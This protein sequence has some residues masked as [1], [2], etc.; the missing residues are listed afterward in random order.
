MRFRPERLREIREKQGVLQ[1]D[2]ALKCGFN[3]FQ[4][5]RYE[6]AKSE[7]SATNLAIIAHHLGVSTDY[8]VG[9]TDNSEERP[10]KA[11]LSTSERE[12]ISIY[13]RKGWPGL[14]GL[15]AEKVAK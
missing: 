4:I 15:G 14:I 6:T 12:I 8:L 2:L 13:R 10:E 3:I 9:L 1:R 7:P 5:S 11:E